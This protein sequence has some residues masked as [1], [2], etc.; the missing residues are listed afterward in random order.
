MKRGGDVEEIR[1]LRRQG[2]SI[3]QIGEQLGCDRKTIRK[4]L[5][6]C[7]SPKYSP[8]EPRQGKLEPFKGYV[9]QR[10]SAGV[11]NAVVLLSEL[12]ERGYAGSY[13]ILREFIAPQRRAALASAVRR[14]ETPPGQQAQVDWGDLGRAQTPAGEHRLCGFVMTLGHSRAMFADIATD[15]TLGTLLLMHEAAFQYL[16]GVPKEIL[17]DWMKT[18]TLGTDAR[19]EVMWNP[20]FLDFARYWGFT[21]KLCRP[22][23]PQTKGKTERGIQY[24]R[25]NFLCGRSAQGVQDVGHQLQVWLAQVANVRVHGTTHRKVQEAWDEERPHLQSLEGRKPY[26]CEPQE[27]RRVAADAYVNYRTNRYS[28]PWQ[29]AGQEVLLS[30]AAGVLTI[31]RDEAVI[32]VHELCLLKHQVIT[33][34]AHHAGMP[35]GPCGKRTSKARLR[36]VEQAPSVEQRDLAEY[37][38]VS[39][40][41]L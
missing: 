19:G 2:L 31:R 18:V 5:K 36:I 37:D 17:Y 9:E 41:R 40:G 22:Y 28:V 20:Q 38:A 39:G 7:R 11:W 25:S 3:K 23:R 16:G 15:E 12:K 13:T 26:P 6:D 29:H 8:R 4:Y 34:R 10:L 32:G 14:F 35:L 33:Q 27:V 30:A 21:P 24:L 1:A